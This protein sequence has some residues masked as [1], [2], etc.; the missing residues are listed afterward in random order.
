MVGIIGLVAHLLIPAKQMGVVVTIGIGLALVLS[1]NLIPAWMS[2]MKK[3]K[4]K[5][6]ATQI[7]SLPLLNNLLKWM[8]KRWF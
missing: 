1:L 4:G 8:G 3:G 7:R 5:N 2:L 6:S